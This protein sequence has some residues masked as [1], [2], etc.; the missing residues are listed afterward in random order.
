M[1]ISWFV[2]MF[3]WMF[4]AS[5]CSSAE[6][7]MDTNQMPTE[8][9][10]LTATQMTTRSVTGTASPTPTFTITPTPF[11]PATA[12]VTETPTITAD[13]N[14][15]MVGPGPILSPIL[16]YHHVLPSNPS[17]TQYAVTMDQFKTQME[18]MK[19]NGYQ[20]VKV[21][22]V[23]DAI[24]YGKVL[25]N[26]PFTITFDDGNID[27]YNNA[28]PILRDLGYTATMYLIE[29]AIGDY[30]NFSIEII[31][32]LA[33]A[34]WEFGSHSRTHANMNTT[35]DRTD[36][37]C[38]SRE[39]LME[40]LQIPIDSF[41]YPYGIENKKAMEKAFCCGYTSGAGIGS[42]TIQTQERLFFFSRREIKSY[43][44]M[45]RFITT[46]TDLR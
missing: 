1:K 40:L 25:P 28:Y 37:I 7:S 22:D 23:V 31:R 5:G 12:T 16:L 43:F 34:G 42:F 35:P 2:L 18:W 36:E 30:G 20:T 38:G 4:L 33:N 10:V 19:E 29:D 11:L 45:Q 8:T 32:E 26:K 6:L 14:F 17:G 21:Q 9:I 24:H 3:G 13:P 44:D 46:V 39:R 15:S 27:V 41:A